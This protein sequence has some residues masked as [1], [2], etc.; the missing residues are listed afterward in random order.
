MGRARSSLV[1]SVHSGGPGRRDLESTAVDLSVPNGQGSQFARALSPQRW[2]RRRGGQKRG[3]TRL[4][5]GHDELR[6]LG[7]LATQPSRSTALASEPSCVVA[8]AL[9]RRRPRVA[10]HSRD[11]VPVPRPTP[12]RAANR[13]AKG[14]GSRGCWWRQKRPRP[15]LAPWRQ[16]ILRFCTP[17]ERTP[18]MKV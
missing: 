18:K 3:H 4:P 12:L 10:S 15:Y 7:T 1:L 17:A 14:F 2:T 16:K 6:L 13:A 5:D 11:H 8:S 9:C